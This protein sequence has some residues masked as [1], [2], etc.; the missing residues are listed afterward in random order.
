MPKWVTA[1]ALAK[2]STPQRTAR[3]MSRAAGKPEL[4]AAMSTP[5]PRKFA[6]SQ[7][8][9]KI[10]AAPMALGTQANTKSVTRPTPGMARAS[11]AKVRKR[12]KIAQNTMTASSWEGDLRRPARP[13][14]D[15][16]PQVSA[17]WSKAT[18][19]ASRL[20]KSAATQA[21][22]SPT[23]ASV[24]MARMLGSTATS[25]LWRSCRAAQTRSPHVSAMVRA[26]FSSAA[27]E[28]VG[29]QDSIAIRSA[30]KSSR[31]ISTSP[32]PTTYPE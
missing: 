32:L 11:T 7:P 8:T 22:T 24:S 5:S 21:A 2:R 17:R 6:M 13:I 19:R 14:A 15:T 16:R 29:Y 27:P 30:T 10:T 26:S 28:R 4:T 20:S 18:A 1:V 12:T 31:I 25:R 23:A 9:R 3:A